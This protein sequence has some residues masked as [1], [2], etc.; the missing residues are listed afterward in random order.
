MWSA[1]SI[2]AAWKAPCM[3]VDSSGLLLEN[4]GWQCMGRA[5]RTTHLHTVDMAAWCHHM[6][7]SRGE[8]QSA[9]IPRKLEALRLLSASERFWVPLVLNFTQGRY[10]SKP[11]QLQWKKRWIL[12]VSAKGVRI[13]QLVDYIKDESVHGS[14]N[15]CI[16]A[17]EPSLCYWSS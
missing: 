1:K 12:T 13:S 6:V 4:P 3:A 5:M 8:A 16:I 7:I 9:N 11:S 15:S 14:W 2:G 17:P 10:W